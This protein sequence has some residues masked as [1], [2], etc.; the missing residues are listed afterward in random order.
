M[1]TASRVEIPLQ[2]VPNQTLTIALGGQ[3]V[4]F[5]ISTFDNSDI[6]S[7]EDTPVSGIYVD[8]YLGS[9][10]ILYG[11]RAVHGSNI[12]QYSSD[13]VGYLMW[14]SDDGTDPTDYTLLGTTY[15]LYYANYNMEQVL[16]DN[17]VY[18]NELFDTTTSSIN[19][20]AVDT[21]GGAT[22]V[23][24]YFLNTNTYIT[25]LS[26]LC[27]SQYTTTGT[28]SITNGL[29]PPEIETGI[30]IYIQTGIF[31]YS[32]TNYAYK[33]MVNITGGTYT[34]I[35]SG[36]SLTLDLISQLGTV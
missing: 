5:A 11:A 1:A 35:I 15:H 4:T 33:M 24:L 2:A 28:I 17:W 22:A 32:S 26:T 16:Y 29:L 10:I 6:S 36:N 13:F 14:Y 23:I 9:T 18:N 31:S 7:N 30:F 12:N 27:N 19:I 34:N 3:N 25:T 20:D 21:S 8:F